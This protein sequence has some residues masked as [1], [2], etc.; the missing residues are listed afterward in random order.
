MSVLGE[1]LSL[2]HF[3]EYS[4]IITYKAFTWFTFGKSGYQGREGQYEKNNVA[5]LTVKFL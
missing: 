4:E 3:I 1:D 2:K 5:Q